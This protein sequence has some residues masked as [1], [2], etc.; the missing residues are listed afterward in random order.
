MNSYDNYYHYNTKMDG[1]RNARLQWS[2]THIE[3]VASY[4]KWNYSSCV[5]WRF[6]MLSEEVY[7]LF[8]VAVDYTTSIDVVKVR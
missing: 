5:A 3:S 4:V 6:I 2:S 1:R 8:F 7:I